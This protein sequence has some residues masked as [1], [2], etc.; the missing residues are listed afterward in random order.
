MYQPAQA[1]DQALPSQCGADRATCQLAPART[2]H[3]CPPQSA[4][5]AGSVFVPGARTAGTKQKTG[6]NTKKHAS[7]RM[8]AWVTQRAT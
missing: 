4:S 3:A 8:R 1:N 2:G 5:T 7:R 6:R